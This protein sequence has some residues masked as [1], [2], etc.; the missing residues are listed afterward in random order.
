MSIALTF[1]RVK[2]VIQKCLD[3]TRTTVYCHSLII[4]SN[5]LT[6]LNVIDFWFSVEIFLFPVRLNG[7]NIYYCFKIA[8]T[9]IEKW[10]WHKISLMKILLIKLSILSRSLLRDQK[11][12]FI[13]INLQLFSFYFIAWIYLENFGNEGLFLISSASFLKLHVESTKSWW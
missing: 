7:L 11:Q 9:R 10:W 1:R 13:F 4:I 6:N 5:S 8:M 3:K 12:L 2:I